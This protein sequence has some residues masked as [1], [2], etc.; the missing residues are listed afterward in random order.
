MIERQG[1]SVNMIRRT[2]FATEQEEAKKEAE[3]EGNV[4][5]VSITPLM[6]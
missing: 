5:I 3:K 2:Y 4:T 6:K 1:K